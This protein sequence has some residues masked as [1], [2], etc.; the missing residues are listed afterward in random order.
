MKK[1]IL[2]LFLIGF[3]V[4]PKGELL[5]RTPAECDAIG[6]A[7]YTAAGGGDAGLAAAAGAC[8][9]APGCYW[10]PA[11][12][13]FCTNVPAAVPANDGGV[14]PVSDIPRIPEVELEIGLER[15]ANALFFILATVAVIFIIIGA[16]TLLT[17]QGDEDKIKTG[18]QQILYAVIA[19][20]VGIL[21]WGI[22]QFIRRAIG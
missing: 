16:F 7:A 6:T 14:A 21:A 12:A 18:R 13:N 17:A 9:V 1:I 20:V 5:A 10:H 15:I 4:V 22:I 8:G 2:A 19:V 11:P 3:L